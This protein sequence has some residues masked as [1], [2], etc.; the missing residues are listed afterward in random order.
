MHLK[1]AQS[2]RLVQLLK[3]SATMVLD[4]GDAICQYYHGDKN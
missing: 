3:N 4:F 1:M 2:R